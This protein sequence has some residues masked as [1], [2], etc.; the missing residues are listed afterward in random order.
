[1]AQEKY[2]LTWHTYSD[3]LKGMMK[4]LMMNEEFSDVTLVTDDKKHIKGNISILS[5][6]SPVFKD[7][8]KKERN[9]NQI[10]YLRDIQFTE[11]ESI[12][13]FIYLGEATFYEERTDEFLAVAK[14]LEIKMLCNANSE[15]NDEI[16]DEPNEPSPGDPDISTENLREQTEVSDLN[17][18]TQQQYSKEVVSVKGKFECE[19]CH[20]TYS[21][22]GAL[23]T[24]KQSA[25]QGVKYSC[26]QC[27]YQTKQYSN[28]TRHIQN[29]H[30]Q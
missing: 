26:D 21:G 1:M 3:H 28:L 23:Y 5:A 29:K 24:H 16:Y 19:Q 30:E 2:S 22:R 13:Q 6:C 7:I 17:Q 20:K 18:E 27:E 10:L 4:E 15:T 11:M 8:L 9:S 12:M 14:S 25:H